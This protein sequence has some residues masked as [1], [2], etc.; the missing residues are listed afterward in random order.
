V[1][2]VPPQPK[3]ACYAY[4]DDE[5]TTM[6]ETTV[7]ETTVPEPGTTVAEMENTSVMAGEITST[8]TAGKKS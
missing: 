6:P 4:V 7:P 2:L 1:Q 3:F 8:A 5:E